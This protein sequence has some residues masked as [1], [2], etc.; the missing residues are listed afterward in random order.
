MHELVKRLLVPRNIGHEKVR[1]G[2]AGDGGYVVSKPCIQNH[3]KAVYSLGIGDNCDFDFELAEMGYPIYQFDGS[4]PA[5]P[6]THKNFYFDSIYVNSETLPNLLK[7]HGH[8]SSNCDL[9]L[10]MDIE[11]VE[12]E[13]FPYLSWQ[14]LD[15]FSQLTFELHNCI[16]MLPHV[17]A[18]LQILSKQFV[19]I[20]INAN[21]VNLGCYE[22]LPRVMELT[23][24]N[25]RVALPACGPSPD[26]KLDFPNEPKNPNIKLDWWVN[27][28]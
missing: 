3:T 9:L 18:L 26:P 11:G 2:T 7:K 16:D 24:V 27:R 12:W 14:H 28:Y 23:W 20:H 1:I 8:D 15:C 17:G 22:Q 25:N 4:I 6:K 13:V 21:N 19:L 5:T 10:K